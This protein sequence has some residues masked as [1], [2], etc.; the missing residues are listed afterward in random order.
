MYDTDWGHH[1]FFGMGLGGSVFMVLFW[2]LLLVALVALLR[3]A[4][5]ANARGDTP[6]ARRRALEILEERYARGEIDDEEYQN[7]R[8]NLD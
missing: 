1:S 4:L 5:S 8:R 7:K 2:V 3:W 6:N